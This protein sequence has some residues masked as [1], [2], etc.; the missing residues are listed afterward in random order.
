[1]ARVKSYEIK[2][3]TMPVKPVSTCELLKM[4]SHYCS[5]LLVTLSHSTVVLYIGIMEVRDFMP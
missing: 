2:A 5:H 3:S 4:T 1:M